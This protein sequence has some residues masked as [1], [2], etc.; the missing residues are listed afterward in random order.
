MSSLTIANLTKTYT[1]S[2]MIKHVVFDNFSLELKQNTI[3]AFVGANGSGKTTLLNCIAGLTQ[4]EKGDIMIDS[5][6]SRDANIGFVFQNYRESLLPWLKN[7]DNI[8]CVIEQPN[9]S[10]LEKHNYIVRVPSLDDKRKV[11]IEPTDQAIKIFKN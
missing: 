1:N 2:N 6:K 10:K 3:T 5:R 7:I 11:L 8:A 4:Y 9:F